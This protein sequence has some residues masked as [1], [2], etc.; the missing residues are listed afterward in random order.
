MHFL[1]TIYHHSGIGDN[2]AK[3]IDVQENVSNLQYRVTRMGNRSI[4][5]I[6]TSCDPYSRQDVG[7]TYVGFCHPSGEYV[8]LFDQRR[9]RER[10]AA[11]NMNGESNDESR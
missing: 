2:R 8:E 3:I 11:N 6:N 5:R 10:P 1:L 4:G 7:E 9:T